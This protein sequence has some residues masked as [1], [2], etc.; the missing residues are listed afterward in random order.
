MK[1]NMYGLTYR[2]M[3]ILH[4]VAEGQ[5]D[6]QIAESLGISTYTVNKHVGNVLGKME[7]SSRTEAGVRA[8][9]EGI[10]S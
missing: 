6:K 8:I 10:V 5:A 9:K 7:A 1:T 2:E 3:A 4:L